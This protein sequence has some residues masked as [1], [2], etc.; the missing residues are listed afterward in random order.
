MIVTYDHQNIFIIQATGLLHKGIY[1]CQGIFTAQAKDWNS[2]LPTPNPGGK[3]FV[4]K[5]VLP[6]K[7]I[8]GYV[9]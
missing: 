6:V 8:Q 4:K 7:V 1:Y 2:F 5:P 9:L 3:G